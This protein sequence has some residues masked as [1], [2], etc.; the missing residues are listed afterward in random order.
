MSPAPKLLIGIAAF[1]IIDAPIPPGPTPEQS[2][3]L[4]MLPTSP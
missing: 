1:G 2:R 3:L 4:L